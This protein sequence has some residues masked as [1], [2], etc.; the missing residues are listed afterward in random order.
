MSEVSFQKPPLIVVDTNALFQSMQNSR[1]YFI[2]KYLESNEAG[3]D[4]WEDKWAPARLF[5]MLDFQEVLLA[6]SPHIIEEVERLLRR[7][8]GKRQRIGKEDH[9]KSLRNKLKR[10]KLV[11][12]PHT[13][14]ICRDPDDDRII[15]CALAAAA[16]DIVTEDEDL[17]SIGSYGSIKILNIVE[18]VRRRDTELGRGWKLS[19]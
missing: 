13:I 8:L 4:Q 10:A 6:T 5:W 11:T 3:I 1:R 16:K 15:E 7:H 2:H 9:F 12:P 18:F 19:I 17:L 14:S